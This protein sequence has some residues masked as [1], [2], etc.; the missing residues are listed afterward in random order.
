MKNKILKIKV[1]QDIY[2]AKIDKPIV[3][4]QFHPEF[5]ITHDNA[6]I[7]FINKFI[8]KIKYFKYILHAKKKHLYKQ[9]NNSMEVKNGRRI[10]YY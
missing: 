7:S 9:N 6:K 10:N 5:Y 4:T 1:I 2:G 8:F 3:F